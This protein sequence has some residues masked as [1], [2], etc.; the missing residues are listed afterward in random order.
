MALTDLQLPVKSDLY[1]TV[2]N[3]AGEV[4]SAKHRWGLIA[5][6][7][8]SM[9]TADL[10]A[11]GVASGQVRTDLVNLRIMLN[12]IVALLNNESVTPTNDPQTVIDNLRKMS[13][14]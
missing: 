14:G 8:N 2:Q 4:S 10:D 9:A 12:E 3:V 6:F 1:N 13:H 11:I 7:L 5:A